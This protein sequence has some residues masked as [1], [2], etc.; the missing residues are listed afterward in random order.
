MAVYTISDTHFEHNNILKYRTQFTSIQEHDEFILDNIL[1]VCGKR[2]S[3]YMLG[4][5]ALGKN[6]FRFVQAIA[7]RVEYLHIVLG[8]HCDERAGSPTAR[9][10]LTVCKNVYGIRRYKGAWLTHAPMHPD[11]LRGK[12]NVH[13]HVH[14]NTLADDRYVNVSCENVA[15][16]PV[17]FADIFEGWR[18]A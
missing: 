10:Y 9:D 18:K 2:D 3:L 14:G 6:S 13:G 17:N 15:Y 11:E 1:T 12:I 4:D 16:K 7:E 5:V 8:N